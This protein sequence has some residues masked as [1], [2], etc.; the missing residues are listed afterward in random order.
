MK[1]PRGPTPHVGL[2]VLAAAAASILCLVVVN[3]VRARLN[4]EQAILSKASGPRAA[5]LNVGLRAHLDC[6]VLRK[7][8]KQ[9]QLGGEFAGLAPLIQAKLPAN[10]RILQGHRCE[11]GGR[12]Y[13]QFIVA[14]SDK[15]LS[16]VLTRKQPGESLSGGIYQEGVDRFQ[17]V[18]FE[19]HDYLVYIISDLDAQQNLRL[20]AGLAPTVREY[21]AALRSNTGELRGVCLAADG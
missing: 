5:V 17:V 2:Y 21:L 12:Q 9:G 11:A 10:F 19:S 18:G 16:L 15:L 1:R 14:S 7:Y 3:R 13:V 8:S 20:A 4:P 6:A